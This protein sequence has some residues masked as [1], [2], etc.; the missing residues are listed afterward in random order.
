ML[1]PPLV[2]PVLA[3]AVLFA[4]TL[5]AVEPATAQRREPLPPPATPVPTVPD[6]TVV[7]VG[8]SL[9]VGGTIGAVAFSAAHENSKTCAVNAS[10]TIECTREE[11]HE[12]GQYVS[13]VAALVGLGVAIYGHWQRGV[14]RA[15]LRRWQRYHGHAA[16]YDGDDGTT[17]TLSGLANSG[18]ANSGLASGSRADGLALT[19]HF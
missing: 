12:T 16:L 3:L 19:L 8:W 1:S 10:D 9:F 14:A 17:L 4:T 2:Q 11:S 13:T 7:I 6:R 5:V 15:R 18:L